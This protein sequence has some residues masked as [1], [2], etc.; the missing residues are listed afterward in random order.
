MSKQCIDYK[1]TTRASIIMILV[2]ALITA[3]LQGNYWVSIA[4]GL[5]AR[6]P[7]V[8]I[9]FLV[10]FVSLTAIYCEATGRI[11]FRRKSEE[12]AGTISKTL[13]LTTERGVLWTIWLGMLMRVGYVLF[14]DINTLQNDGGTFTGFGTTQINNGHIGYIEYIYKF[15]HLPT[16]DPYEYFGYYH[17]P[18]HHIIEA[19]W[20]TVQRFLGVAE[21][22][23]FE[24]LQIPTLIYSGLCMVVMLQI[25]KESDIN[26]KYVIPGMMLFAFHPR[27]MVLAGSVNNDILA[28]LLLLCTIWRTLVWIR[29]KNIKNIVM[30]ALS[31][32][33]GMI[34]KLNTAICAFSI[35][36][37]FLIVLVNAFK[38]GNLLVRKSVITQF[39]IFTVVCVPI[40]LSYIVRNMVLF[41]EKPG[42]PS[43]AIIPNESVMYTGPYSV[44]S[45]IGIPALSDWNAA[46]PFHPISAEASHNT[47]VI[48]F[49]T[50][51]FAE[52]YPA[53][54]NDYLLSVAQIAYVASIITAVATTI[55]FLWVYLK[56]LVKETRKIRYSL[57]Y[58]TDE[59]RA[60]GVI[61]TE[62]ALNHMERSVFL[63]ITYVFML[64]SFCLYVFKY[65]YTCSSDFRYMTACLVFTSIGFVDVQ[66]VCG[67]GA[68]KVVKFIVNTA[69]AAC[70]IGS[71]LVYMF[72]DI[73]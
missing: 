35:A 47:W 65:P 44:W 46:F 11:R 34:S 71:L 64:L 68:R 45:I 54:M 30:I 27:M 42:I 6:Q 63:W 40:G 38:D 55:V 23:A 31:L 69:M 39:V 21:E 50:G 28:L 13:N 2:M 5:A 33:F 1:K 4:G 53:G 51:L 58:P 57:A 18:L 70:L 3:V 37:I 25:L 48:L 22:L 73:A 12:K 24:N 16:M 10:G 62:E 9:L 32:G 59:E 7:Q 26:E 8:M 66:T 36:V 61:S 56:K 17:P 41:G 19:L 72:W 43:P 49:Q 60:K 52:A 15:F 14:F 67:K 20:L 29:E